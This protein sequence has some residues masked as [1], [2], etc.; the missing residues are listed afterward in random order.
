[1]RLAG[2]EL[3]KRTMVFRYLEKQQAK[4]R[5]YLTGVTL[6]ILTMSVCPKF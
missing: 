6:T 4:V 3:G 5:M 2:M 1:M